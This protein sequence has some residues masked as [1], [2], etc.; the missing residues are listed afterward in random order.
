[1]VKS[2]GWT[3]KFLTSSENA[4]WWVPIRRQREC[5]EENGS[6]FV[7]VQPQLIAAHP[8]FYVI[9]AWLHVTYK[10]FYVVW[11]SWFL[12]LGVIC[13]ELMVDWMTGY[14]VWKWRNVQDAQY[15]IK[16]QTLWNSKHQRRTRESRAVSNIRLISVQRIWSKPLEYGRADAKDCLGTG[17]K[18]LVINSIESSRKIQ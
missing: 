17:E 14:D 15:S 18:N 9:F 12:K 6:S 4:V 16:Q 11:W 3:P 8:W 13:K 5:W 2:S 1:M 10:A 7:L